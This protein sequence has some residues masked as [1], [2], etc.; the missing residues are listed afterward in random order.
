[1]AEHLG[2]GLG[3][4]HEAEFIDDE[5]LIAGDLLL[6]AE[7]LLLI[8]NLDQFADQR[9]GGSEAHAVAALAGSQA[10]SQCDVGLPPQR[11]RPVAGDPGLAGAGVTEQSNVLMAGD[12]LASRQLQHHGLIQ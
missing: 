10:K 6:E 2:S 5:Q 12:E 7:Q 11:R 1:M 8:A 4:G 9:G 3:Q